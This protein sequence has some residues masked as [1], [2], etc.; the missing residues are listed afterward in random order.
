MGFF[1]PQAGRAAVLALVAF[2]AFVGLGRLAKSRPKGRRVAAPKGQKLAV[3]KA[4]R[5]YWP[6]R[7]G[8][9]LPNGL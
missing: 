3:P 5:P 9:V 6:Y 4:E 1:R 7:L 2:V 8:S